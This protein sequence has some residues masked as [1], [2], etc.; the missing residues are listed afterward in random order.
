MRSE[1]QTN[2]LSIQ[3]DKGRKRNLIVMLHSVGLEEGLLNE[4][5][6]PPLKS[7][8]TSTKNSIISLLPYEPSTRHEDLHEEWLIK[9]VLWLSPTFGG[10][11]DCSPRLCQVLPALATKGAGDEEV[12]CCIFSV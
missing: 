8:C 6:F 12:E 3:A 7:S 11:R 2:Y 1:K 5:P 10:T 4:P 9:L